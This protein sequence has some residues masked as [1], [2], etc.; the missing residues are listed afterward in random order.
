M[1]SI[2]V[3]VPNPFWAL[4]CVHYRPHAQND[5]DIGRE[6]SVVFQ[7]VNGITKVLTRGMTWMDFWTKLFLK[8]RH[9]IVPIGIIACLVVIL[10]PLPPALLDILLS[11]NIAIAVVILLTTSG[12]AVT[13]SSSRSAT[14]P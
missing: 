12:S 7:I 2:K 3:L 11:A 1:Q 4:A 13:G 14:A 10:V 8:H 6:T 9:A 5:I